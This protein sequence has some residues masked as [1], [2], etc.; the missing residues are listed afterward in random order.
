MITRLEAQHRLFNA[1][2]ILLKRGWSQQ[3][4]DA[5][6]DG[7]HRED[8]VEA[9]ERAVL[10]AQAGTSQFADDVIAARFKGVK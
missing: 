10:V 4:V 3:S 8:A 1:I 6:I 5:L 9:A 7:L 2:Q